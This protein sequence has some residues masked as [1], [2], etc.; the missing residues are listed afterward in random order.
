[1]I[2]D[3]VYV[4]VSNDTGLALVVCESFEKARE[5]TDLYT[6]LDTGTKTWNVQ[7][8]KL[9]MAKEDLCSLKKKKN[10]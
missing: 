4:V 9:I 7:K 1:M 5:I 6:E 10:Y 8:R 3:T 2:F